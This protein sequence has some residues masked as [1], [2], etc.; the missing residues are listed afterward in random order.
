[1]TDWDYSAGDLSLHLQLSVVF[2][3]CKFYLDLRQDSV[4]YGIS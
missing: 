2:V 1:V 4:D 3:V